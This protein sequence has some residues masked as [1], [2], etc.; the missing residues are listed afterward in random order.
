LQVVHDIPGDHLALKVAQ[1]AQ[2]TANLEIQRKGYVERPGLA[3]LS[4]QR[5]ILAVLAPYHASVIERD[6]R[7]AERENIPDE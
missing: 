4:G 5:G 6:E 2:T 3:I 7:R 1:G